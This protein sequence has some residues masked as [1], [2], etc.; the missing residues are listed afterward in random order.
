M[1]YF[2]NDSLY[3]SVLDDEICLFN[4]EIGKYHNLNKVGSLIWEILDKPKDIDNIVNF[5]TNKF[6]VSKEQC[7]LE[8]K[9]FLKIAVK[10]KILLTRS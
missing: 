1:E 7:F 3:S 8:T 6:E 5:L 2:R 4:S 10:E 9:N